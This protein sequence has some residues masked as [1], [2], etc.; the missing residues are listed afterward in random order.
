[1]IVRCDWVF[2]GGTK[3]SRPGPLTDSLA[4]RA[5][6]PIT[7][8]YM[9]FNDT[10]A[11]AHNH[12]VYSRRSPLVFPSIPRESPVISAARGTRPSASFLGGKSWIQLR[13]PSFIPEQAK[14][15]SIGL[16][17]FVIPEAAEVIMFL[18]SGA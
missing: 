3:S 2:G 11:E 9:T 6:P 8:A 5:H 14:N 4:Y 10:Q 18:S 17:S 15:I 7:E 1:M 12:A 16:R 13:K